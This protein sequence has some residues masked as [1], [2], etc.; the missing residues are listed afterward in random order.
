MNTNEFFNS[1]ETTQQDK[2]AALVKQYDNVE[3]KPNQRIREDKR[4]HI[5]WIEEKQRFFEGGSW[6]RC[7]VRIG[8]YNN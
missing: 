8:T 6:H 2:L 3:L 1:I 4:T 5:L 7:W